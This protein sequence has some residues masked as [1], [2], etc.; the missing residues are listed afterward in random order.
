MP[1]ALVPVWLVECRS[2]YA[3]GG[4]PY[5]DED[6]R[7][8][9]D[10]ALR[11]GLL[12][13]IGAMIGTHSIDIAWRPD[14]MHVNDWQTALLPVMQRLRPGPHPPTVLA[15]HN[16]AHQGMFAADVTRRLPLPASSRA[17]CREGISFLKTGILSADRVV[18]VSPTYAAEIQTSAY[19][20]GLDPVLRQLGN[21][22]HGIL[23]GVDYATW[24]PASDPSLAVH[25]KLTDLSKKRRCK[26][27]IQEEL[28]LDVEAGAP[29]LAFTS[30][31]AWQK[32]PD[33]VLEVLPPLVAEG[34]QFALVAEGDRRYEAAFLRLAAT[35]PGR[36]AV[37]IGYEEAVAHR[38]MAGADMLLN[39]ARY[40]PFGLTAP[41]ALRYGTPPIARRT[42]GL[43]DTVVDVTAH[44]LID[45]SATGFLFDNPNA[46]ET[47][48]CIRR[49]LR[50]FRQKTAWRRI[51]IAGML[52]DFGWTRSARDY[53]ALYR[54]MIGARA[55]VHAMPM[56]PN[57]AHANGADTGR[58][59]RVRQRAYEIWEAQGKPDGHHLEHWLQAEAELSETGRPSPPLP[60]RGRNCRGAY[61]VAGALT[62]GRAGGGS[63]DRGGRSGGVPGGLL[64][65]LHAH[66]RARPPARRRP[67]RPSSAS[68]VHSAGH[69]KMASTRLGEKAR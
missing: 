36:V 22:V 61:P 5:Q 3:R 67:H 17:E 32:M 23:N 35:Y 12:S 2:L 68:R 37:Q 41:Y 69:S 16:L 45:G 20:C 53:A 19:G 31:L 26:T 48:A 55:T 9:S 30:R 33:V 15:I 11:F 42:G 27:A 13:Y 1:G 7:D 49:A 34:I 4:N 14:L 59:E 65:R 6:G 29:L 44:S 24:D 28:G 62:Q 51:Q 66:R 52:R 60:R 50:L 21:P 57:E 10:N 63:A 38:L 56:A 43:I 8:F 64:E 25:Y 18:T 46:E 39:P 47:L 40:E 54:Q 58:A